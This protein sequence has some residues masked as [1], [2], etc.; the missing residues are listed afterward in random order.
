MIISLF[1]RIALY[2]PIQVLPYILSILKLYIDST[3]GHDI[4]LLAYAC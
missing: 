4:H 3:C 2:K 1:T